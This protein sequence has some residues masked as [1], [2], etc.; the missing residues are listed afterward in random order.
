MP[1]LSRENIF[2]AFGANGQLNQFTR[3]PF[4]PKKAVYCFH[5]VI[6]SITTADDCKGAFAYSNDIIVREETREEQDKN[7]K[8]LLEAVD[9]CGRTFN[10]KKC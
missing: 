9:K 4:G 1:I 8:K 3:I 2:T 6:D 10:D 5:K 7:L